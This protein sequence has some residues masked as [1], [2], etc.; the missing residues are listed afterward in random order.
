MTKTGQHV[1]PN[2]G[3][4]SVKRSGAKRATK[5]FETQGEAI[6]AAREIAQNQKT[7]LYIHRKDGRI[8]ERNSYGSDPF[9]PK[10]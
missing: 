9:P 5:V 3:G 4:W 10:G 2:P 8:R 6:A 7:E 1:L